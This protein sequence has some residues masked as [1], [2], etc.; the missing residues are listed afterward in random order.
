M[1]FHAPW[2]AINIADLPKLRLLLPRTGDIGANVTA[3]ARLPLTLVLHFIP[4]TRRRRILSSI[5]EEHKD[6]SHAEVLTADVFLRKL[7][8]SEI[9]ARKCFRRHSAKLLASGIG[10]L[11][12]ML[13]GISVN[14][15]SVLRLQMD[16][17]PVPLLCTPCC[18][19]T[20]QY[21]AE[22]RMPAIDG[23]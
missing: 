22:A 17:D 15:V 12:L 14:V 21:C 4:Q 1:S 10:R 18:V 23:V 2:K 6:E 11:M 19:Q 13:R 7:T 3:T 5:D 9:M 16:I 8:L 20:G